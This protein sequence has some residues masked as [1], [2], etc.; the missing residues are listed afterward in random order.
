[1]LNEYAKGSGQT[2][3]GR[4]EPTAG[5]VNPNDGKGWSTYRI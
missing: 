2:E 4:I 3:V 1:V 5:L